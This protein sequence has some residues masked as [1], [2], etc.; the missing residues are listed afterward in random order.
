V[1]GD[2][3]GHSFLDLFSGSGVLGV[4]AASRG[5]W[6]VVCVEKDPQKRAQLIKNLS[7]SEQ[8]IECHIMPVEL[9]LKR[10]KGRFDLIF[11]DPPFPYAFRD[12]LIAT[13]A[14]RGILAPSGR[15]LMHRPKEDRP[16]PCP[17][18]L[19][20]ADQRNYGRSIIDIYR[21]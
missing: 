3:A 11:C 9:F 7:I 8:R 5:A 14:A 10:T 21:G 2:I 6:P 20:C 13:I 17:Q 1:L 18:G 16:G 15:L 19:E 4:E 12:D